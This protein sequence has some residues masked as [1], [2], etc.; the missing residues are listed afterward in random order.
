MGDLLKDVKEVVNP[1]Q[2]IIVIAA[3]CCWAVVEVAKSK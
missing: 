3:V 2:A 1:Y